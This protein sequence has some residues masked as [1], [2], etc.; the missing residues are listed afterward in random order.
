MV[1]ACVVSHW[2][3]G[4]CIPPVSMPPGCKKSGGLLNLGVVAHGK[5][6]LKRVKRRLLFVRPAPACPRLR[7]AIVAYHSPHYRGASG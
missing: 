4:R 5:C 3:G 6:L 2:C 1:S 7:I